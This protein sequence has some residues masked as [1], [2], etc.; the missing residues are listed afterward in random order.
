LRE[1]LLKTNDNKFIDLEDNIQL[2]ANFYNYLYSSKNYK[3]YSKPFFDLV[4]KYNID[5]NNVI[6]KTYIEQEGKESY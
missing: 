3:I 1:L 6:E 2:Y 4:K 5:Y